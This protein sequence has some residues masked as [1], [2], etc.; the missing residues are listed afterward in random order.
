MAGNSCELSAV[1]VLA[2][3]S[4]DHLEIIYGAQETF[5][6]III[7]VENNCAASYFCG[8]CDIFVQVL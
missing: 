6:I 8:N 3:V 5:L 2:S 4:H 1:V 7:N